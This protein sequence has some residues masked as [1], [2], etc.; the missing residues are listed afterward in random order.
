MAMHGR[1][2]EEWKQRAEMAESKLKDL[3]FSPS[4]GWSVLHEQPS[5]H[6]E[7]STLATATS[8]AASELSRHPET[9]SSFGSCSFH[10]SINSSYRASFDP[11]L[12]SHCGR[13]LD[14]DDD[15][16][17]LSCVDLPPAHVPELQPSCHTG[18]TSMFQSGPDVPEGIKARSSLNSY[19]AREATRDR[20]SVV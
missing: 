10:A 20:K 15:S 7:G 12:L 13:E 19:G 17:D 9:D 4:H 18:S 2:A 16:M 1:K 11:S 8:Y 5:D 3:R 6:E 14:F